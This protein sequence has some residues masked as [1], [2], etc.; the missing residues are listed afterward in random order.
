[1]NIELFCV[2]QLFIYFSNIGNVSYLIL[3]IIIFSIAEAIVYPN[4]NIQIDRLAPEKHRGAYLGASSL[5]ILGLSIGPIISGF[6]LKETIRG[7]FLIFFLICLKVVYLQYLII[8]N[9]KKKVRY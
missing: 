5:I 7:I 4:L 8:R 9:L 3:L 2:F 1:M 6:F